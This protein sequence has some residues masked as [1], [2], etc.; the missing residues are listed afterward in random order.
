MKGLPAPSTP[1]EMRER[2]AS[3]ATAL[4]E[5]EAVPQLESGDL[6]ALSADKVDAIR[7]L[8]SDLAAQEPQAAAQVIRVWLTEG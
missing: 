4:G 1:A 2:L 6:K 3:S 7:K 5:E 8:A